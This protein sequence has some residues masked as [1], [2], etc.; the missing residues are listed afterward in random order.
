M[1]H[2]VLGVTVF[3]LVL[4]LVT[5]ACRR[6]SL[7]APLVLILV[8]L[9]GSYLP[10]IQEPHLSPEM[11]LMGALPP[12][13]YSSAINTSLVDFRRNIST[14]GW[15]SIG[16]VLFT[17]FGAGAIIHLCLGLSWAPSLAIGAIIAPPDAV[18]ATAVARSIGLPR[19]VVT[20]LEGESL[21]ND[22]TAL[23]SMNSAISAMTASVAV[24]T[25]LF[26]FGRAVVVAVLV[27]LVVAKLAGL[28]FK[29]LTDAVTSVGLSLVIPFLAYVPAEELGGSGVLAVV[30]AGLLL[31]NASPR[32]QSGETRQASRVNW[33]TVQFVLENAVFLMI[34]LQV[35]SIVSGVHT[36]GI[37]LPRVVIACAA[38]LVGVMVLRVVWIVATRLAIHIGPTK[39]TTPLNE[40]L[41]ISW[42]GMRGVVT[43]AG[44]LALPETTPH[45][46]VLV[47]IALVV[48]LGTLLVQG[49][50][51]PMVA[52]RLDIHGPDPRED[53]LQEATI[54]QHAI[55]A[56]EK[57]A[58]AAARPGDEDLLQQ[59]DEADERRINS[60]WERLGRPE[61]DVETPSQGYRRL[62]R[63][64]I[65]GE[66]EE[67]LRIRDAGEADHEVLE[68]VL[69]SL[70]GEEAA[71]GRR[72]KAAVAVRN[73]PLRPNLPDAPCEHL[74]SSPCSLKPQTP[75]Y[76][77]ECRE[78]GLE[79]VHL[80]LCLECGHVGCCDSSQGKHASAHFEQTGHP[81]MRSLEPGEDW[82]WC[83]VDELVGPGAD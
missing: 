75:G 57:A 80:R 8:G 13:L 70:D 26:D 68:R 37:P 67:L 36:G 38:A 40:A 6:F 15:L 77:P 62:R 5:S 47:M 59:M 78:L 43:L 42:A 25:V 81:T 54:L 31:G 71:L 17:T 29:R 19:R 48:T 18:A 45:R 64:A 39:A 50:S 46:P 22:A 49:I 79:P 76:C 3:L 33:R 30:V 44:A 41:V 23:V 24:G 61:S 74:A 52:R 2:L 21:V 1:A 60:V 4:L 56:G 55:R 10:F 12:L 20:V 34:G 73:A 9:V 66:R 69:A 16:L 32:I 65:D 82:R 28:W 11:V 27:G 83:F 7:N 63:A 72:R 53:T 14:I 58:A 51:L 35:R